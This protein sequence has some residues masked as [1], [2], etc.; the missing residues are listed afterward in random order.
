MPMLDPQQIED[1]YPLT[2]MQRGMLFHSLYA[3]RS[4]VYF[5]QEGFRLEGRLDRAAFVRAWELVLARHSILRT[6]IVWEG[7]DEPVQVVFRRVPLPLE[8]HDWRAMPPAEQPAAIA[9]FAQA[10]RER[11]FDTVVAPLMRLA[12]I[13]LADDAYHFIWSRHHLLLDGWSVALLLKE[14]LRCYDALRQ[15]RAPGLDRP[16]PYREY[17]AWLQRQDVAQAEQ[18]WRATLAGFRAPTPLGVDRASARP[19]GQEQYAEQWAHITPATTAALQGLARSLRVTVNTLFQG[20]WA[21]M[22]SR[23]SGQADVLFG[24]TNSGRP[25]ALAGVEGM[26]GLFINTLPVRVR[27]APDAPLAPWLQGI[28]AQQGEARQFN[29]S[30]LVDIQRW[31]ELPR[32]APL[33]E[34]LLVFEN[35]PAISE[36]DL[37]GDLAVRSEHSFECTNYPL[38]LAVLPGP[39]LAL[40]AIYDC[41]RFDEATIA[42]MLGHLQ[43]LLGGM[44]ANP[45]QRLADLPM[46]GAAERLALVG[47]PSVAAPAPGVLALFEEQAARSPDA[48]AVVF[49]QRSL[50]FGELNER[51]NQLAHYLR[52]RGVGPEVRVGVCLERSLDLAVGLLAV[53]KAGGACVPLDPAEPFVRLAAL[54]AAA[55]AAVL[56]TQDRLARAMPAAGEQ[57]PALVRVDADWPAIGRA[58]RESPPPAYPATLALVSIGAGPGALVSHAALAERLAALQHACP[59]GPGD[60]ALH[61]A[62]LAADAAAWE[63]LWPLARGARLVLA[64]PA[65]HDDPA[66]LRAL[67]GQQH[68]SVLHLAAP[69]LAA[70]LDAW[71]PAPPELPALRAVLCSGE[72]PAP[73]L[74]ERLA[75]M[76]GARLL[77]LYAPA[78]AGPQPLWPARQGAAGLYVLDE[79]LRL[80]P[81]GV[82]GDLYL[83]EPGLAR[84]R[85]SAA[86]TAL[87]YLPDPFAPAPGARMYRT[88]ERARRL[89][90]GSLEL[91][92]RRDRLVWLADRRADMREVEAALLADPA[93]EDCAVLAR[94]WPTWCPPARSR[95]SSCRHA[96]ARA[97]PPRCALPR[98]SRWRSCRS[99]PAATP[100]RPRWRRSSW[101]TPS[102]C[103]AGR[104]T[105][106]RCPAWAR[107]WCWRTSRPSARRRCTFPT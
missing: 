58:P 16:R 6:A 12:L 76:L 18:Y 82:A 26:A 51:A 93:V 15:A 72:P 107:R 34:S 65:G 75:A 99:R 53:L 80:L 42:R 66:E 60:T 4:A 7:L 22:L 98:T 74:A 102:C 20:A 91:L 19:A 13:Q 41:D 46:L 88:G 32:G 77:A 5:Q 10:D 21:L 23:Y 3:P 100:T 31:S 71:A 2:P 94:C 35:F 44:L 30:S 52:A 48:V 79:A 87:A 36:D 89:S 11:G 104:P 96:C 61:L 106:R 103:G 45:Q 63:L 90:D 97:C 73:A 38:N 9:A 86:A 54:F 84:G 50:S 39:G 28:L 85:P 24:A 69:V 8:Q 59:L 43:A 101:S 37:A 56:L 83:A 27:A 57:G 29:Y 40:R 55:G 14:A 78:E 68:A 105:S 67:L 92:G 62:S 25:T 47:A 1:I 70:A 33:F 49:E 64:L 17:L 81:L 95:P